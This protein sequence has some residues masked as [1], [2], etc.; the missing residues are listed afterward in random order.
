MIIIHQ[1]YCYEYIISQYV[2]IVNIFTYLTVKNINYVI[3][4][5]LTLKK[6]K[7]ERLL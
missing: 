1:Y 6:A 7:K 4:V 5:A 2:Y 3:I